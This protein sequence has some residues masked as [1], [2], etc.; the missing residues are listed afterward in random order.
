MSEMNQFKVDA[1]DAFFLTS[2]DELPITI[3]TA[4]SLIIGKIQNNFVEAESFE[5]LHDKL[6]EIDASDLEKHIA[7]TQYIFQASRDIA[8]KKAETSKSPKGIWLKDVTLIFGSLNHRVKMDT[9]FLFLDQVAGISYGLALD[10]QH[11]DDES[12]Y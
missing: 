11:K 12:D 7:T 9:Y 4:N 5:T 8:L 3:H 2:N 10:D 1:M 6:E